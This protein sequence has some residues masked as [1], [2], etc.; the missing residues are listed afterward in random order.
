MP[1]RYEKTNRTFTVALRVCDATVT[2]LANQQILLEWP[3]IKWAE[4]MGADMDPSS[5]FLCTHRF[6]ESTHTY[7]PIDKL[8]LSTRSRNLH[9]NLVS[10]SKISHVRNT[11]GMSADLFANY[12]VVTNT[13]ALTN[14]T[15]SPAGT[16]KDG[17]LNRMEKQL[18]N[19][20][21]VAATSTARLAYNQSFG[22]VYRCE[23]RTFECHNPE[24]NST[25]R[26]WYDDD[27]P[28][29]TMGDIN[30]ATATLNGSSLGTAMYG[31]FNTITSVP[32]TGSVNGFL[33]SFASVVSSNPSSILDIGPPG[34]THVFEF[35]LVIKHYY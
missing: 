11:D 29:P 2:R 22:G 5:T 30:S 14:P 10:F 35:E 34:G 26:I 33:P 17:F 12:G 27:V 7:Q 8:F 20:V 25:V 9:C 18:F 32:T 16:F 21:N 4:H 23:K 6:T 28:V 31:P 19:G 1:I 13:A 24:K 3:N 15:G